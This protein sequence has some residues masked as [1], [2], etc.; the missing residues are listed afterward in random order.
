MPQSA[1]QGCSGH[2]A[3]RKLKLRPYWTAKRRIVQV[4]R[5]TIPALPVGP[6]WIGAGFSGIGLMASSCACLLAPMPQALM[7]KLHVLE[8]LK[9]ELSGARMEWSAL[10]HRT[11]PRCTEPSPKSDST[12]ESLT[13]AEAQALLLHSPVCQPA[14]CP[15]DP[16]RP[17]Q[18]VA[19]SPEEADSREPGS[20]LLATSCNHASQRGSITFWR[21][22]PNRRSA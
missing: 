12:K 10:P 22:R 11:S 9:S 6:S 8:L 3:P 14:P 7:G 4:P 5:V 17:M 21:T 1:E 2:L 20:Y 18:P 19:G 13:A 15:L 16:C